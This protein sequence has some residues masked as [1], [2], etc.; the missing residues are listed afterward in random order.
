MPKVS[1]LQILGYTCSLHYI[2]ILAVTGHNICPWFSLELFGN[3]LKESSDQLIRRLYK[4]T[5]LL[6][7]LSLFVRLVEHVPF[8]D[9]I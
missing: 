8:F 6:C 3:F 2:Q 5:L 1:L 9:R 7:E 4:G